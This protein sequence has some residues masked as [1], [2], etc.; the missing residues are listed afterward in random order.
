MI[1]PAQRMQLLTETFFAALGPKIE[2]LQAAGKD[3]IC[4]D[5]GSP[6]LPPA[7]PIIATLAHSAAA[8]TT[9]SYQ[10]HRGPETLRSAW[11]EMY[12]RVYGGQPGCGQ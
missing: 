5:E 3:V 8:S 7:P 10:P 11:V 2:A 9:H 1:L 12:R 4:L 6:D